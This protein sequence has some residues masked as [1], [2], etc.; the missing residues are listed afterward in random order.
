MREVNEEYWNEY[1]DMFN[2]REYIDLVDKYYAQDATFQ[3]PLHSLKGREQ[4][5][6]HFTEK[7]ADVKEHM[8]PVTSVL[9]QDVAAFEVKSELSSKKDL[10]DFH[11]MPLAEGQGVELNAGAFFHLDG[12]MIKQVRIYWMKPV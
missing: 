12:D 8:I 2:S 7:H 4:I 6:D 1:F 10:P 9:T 11:L 5:A 3:T